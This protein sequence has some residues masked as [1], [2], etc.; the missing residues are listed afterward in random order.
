MA[1][2]KVKQI[3]DIQ[4][5]VQGLIDNDADQNATLIS[6]NASSISAVSAALST[7][8]STTNDEVSELQASVDSLELIAGGTVTADLAASVDSLESVDAGLASDIA[9]NASGIAE[10]V[11]DISALQTQLDANDADNVTLTASVD[12]LELLAGGTIIAD[13]AASVLDNDTRVDNI[14]QGATAD[15]NQFAEVIAYVNSIDTVGDLDLTN[16]LA[17]VNASID[18]LEDVDTALSTALSTEIDTSNSG[19]KALQDSVDSLETFE[20]EAIASIDSLELLAGGSTIA[21]LQSDLDAVSDALSTEISTTNDEVSDLQDSVDALE[22]ADVMLHQE[23]TVTAIDT[24][25]L[26]APVRFGISDDI[27]VHVNG[28]TIKPVSLVDGEAAPNDHGWISA[29]GRTFNFVGI[30]YDIDAE[31]VVYVQAIKA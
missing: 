5:Y 29:D 27:H 10:N 12:S 8:V 15:L 30:G 17:V 21:D 19:I 18:S 20:D 28:H 31:D 3:S 23:G 6:N 16:A 14:L 7:E 25:S 9:T 26:V 4:T 11:K 22:A 2:L 24:F 1:R 13:L